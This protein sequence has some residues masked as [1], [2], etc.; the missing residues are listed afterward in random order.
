MLVYYCR[1]K[2]V[3][4]FERLNQKRNQIIN[5]GYHDANLLSEME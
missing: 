2:P 5:Q 1:F 4:N 3:H